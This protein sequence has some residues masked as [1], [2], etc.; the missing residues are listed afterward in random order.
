MIGEWIIFPSF[1][2]DILMT[3]QS[4]WAVSFYLLFN[5]QLRLMLA[6]DG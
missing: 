3:R 1:G 2:K 4:F 6:L 5:R